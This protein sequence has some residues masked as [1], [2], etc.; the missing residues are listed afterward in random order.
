[1]QE[2]RKRIL[3]EYLDSI[4]P[5]MIEFEDICDTF[6]VGIFNEVR[7]VFFHLAKYEVLPSGKTKDTEITKAENHM[8]RAKRDCYKYLCVGYEKKYA[9]YLQNM[10]IVSAVAANEEEKKSIK[11]IALLH[12]TCVENLTAARSMEKELEPNNDKI[13]TAYE[14]AKNNYRELHKK[15]KYFYAC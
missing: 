11:E 5:M 10:Q 2:R 7:A 3:Q 1:M 8:V 13:Y 9:Q 15:I 6:P 14:Q 12:E 4:S